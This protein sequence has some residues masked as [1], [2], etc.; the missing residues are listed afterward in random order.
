MGFIECKDDSDRNL[1]YRVKQTKKNF[2][3][4]TR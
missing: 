4:P 1:H 2:Y 3:L